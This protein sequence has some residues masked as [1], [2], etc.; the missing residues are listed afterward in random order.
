MWQHIIVLENLRSCYNV[1]NIIRTADALWWGIIICWYTPAPSTQ[2]KVR[3]T[4]LWAEDAIVIEEYVDTK[5]ATDTLTAI[6]VLHERG[7]YVVAAEVKDDAVCLRDFSAMAADTTPK[8]AV[9]FG[10]EVVGIESTTLAK[11]DKIV[12]I[13]MMGVKESLN[14]WQ[15]AAIF[16]RELK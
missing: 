5:T 8:I 13:P 4:S 1:W 10:N 11:V 9:I 16:M 3:K 15:T 12:K 2:P 7:Y 6:D 14:V